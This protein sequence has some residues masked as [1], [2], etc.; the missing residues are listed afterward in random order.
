MMRARTGHWL[1]RIATGA[2]WYA[3]TLC[4]ALLA[5]AGTQNPAWAQQTPFDTQRATR[6]P[7]RIALAHTGLSR[8][9]PGLLLRDIQRGEEDVTQLARALAELVPDILVLLD[10]DHDLEGRALAAFADALARR[11][12]EMPHSFAPPGNRGRDTG[13]D[14]NGDGRLGTPEDGQGWGEFRGQGAMALLSRWPIATA[15]V[16]NHSAFLWRD[17][18]EWTVLPDVQISLPSVSENFPQAAQAVQHLSTT[19]HWEVPIQLGADRRLW[20]FAWHATPPAFDFGRDRNLRRN[21]AETVFWLQRLAGAFGPLPSEPVVLIGDTNLDPQ[22]GE[23]QRSVISYL[24][25]HPMLQDPHPVAEQPPPNVPS[26]ATA[27]WPDGPGALRVDYVL[28]DRALRVHDT[29]LIWP[30]PEAR[31][32]IVWVDVFLRQ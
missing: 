17:L 23:G 12:H 25:R 9:G 7:V 30:A 1:C 14:M 19:S 3:Q 27:H 22:R 2:K 4:V 29:G 6:A 15:D 8:N 16:Q 26:D 24:L 10:F 5:F 32:A 11:G 20:L 28:P 13:R 31:H 21:A 18:P